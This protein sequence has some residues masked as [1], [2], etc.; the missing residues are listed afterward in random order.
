MPK[1]LI[2]RF[3]SI[4]DIVLTSPVI[5]CLKKQIRHAE[6]H[7]LTKQCFAPVIEFNP[8]IDKRILLRDSLSKISAQLKSEKYDYIIDL[9]HN[10][11]SLQVKSIVRTRSF[12]F[13]KKNFDKWKMVNLKAS[14]SVP[15]VVDRY[16][17]AVESL[18]VKNDGEGLEFFLPP[19]L[20]QRNPVES[21]YL[22]ALAVAGYIAVVVGANHFTKEPTDEMLA[23]ICNESVKP[24]V[25][26]GGNADIS[27]AERVLSLSKSPRTRVLNF[28][29]KL[30]LHESA[31]IVKYA[32][33]VVTPDTGMMHIAAAFSKQLI[34]LWGNT[35]PGFGM[36]PYFRSSTQQAE[37]YEVKDLDC[38]P[39]SKIG[40]K[41]CPKKHF[42]CMKWINMDQLIDSLNNEL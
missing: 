38:R 6:V 21:G 20:E 27:K 19:E 10:L 33:K 12:S 4:G 41:S 7:F 24:V 13:P 39:C 30:T 16:F 42:H 15:H 17:K 3:S 11:R 31:W 36:T 1:F 40:F 26:I 18:G 2:I 22:S 25:L 35:V 34:T 32:D 37:I 8:G 14:L 9:H 28:C 5:R 29:G 23:R